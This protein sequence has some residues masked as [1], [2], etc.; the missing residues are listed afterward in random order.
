[1]VERRKSVRFH[2]PVPVVLK[3]ND[4]QGVAEQGGGFSR[5]ISTAGIFV[6][7]SGF[8]PEGA[9]ITIEVALPPLQ[10]GLQGLQLRAAGRI[11]RVERIGATCGVAAVADFAMPEPVQAEASQDAS[12]PRPELEQANGS[13]SDGRGWNLVRT[14]FVAD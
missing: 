9:E 12:A 6:H 2:L 7:C 3:W 1:M 11:V 5:D 4:G 14:G 8:P 10:A 13:K